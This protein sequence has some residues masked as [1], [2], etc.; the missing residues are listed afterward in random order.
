ML[1]GI[2]GRGQ[3]MQVLRR[4]LSKR[5]YDRY[6]AAFMDM[7]GLLLKKKIKRNEEKYAEN[8]STNQEKPICA[9]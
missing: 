2:H 5:E 4:V 7:R 6:M 1:R 8:L 9:A 3:K